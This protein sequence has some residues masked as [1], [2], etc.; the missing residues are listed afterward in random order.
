MGSL[1]LSCIKKTHLCP[2]ADK[3]GEVLLIVVVQSLHVLGV[4][5]EPVHTGEVF[6]LG[7]LL[8]KTPE[9][10]DNAKGGTGD[11]VREVTTRRADSSNNG[12]AALSLRVAET[13]G[14]SSTLVEGSQ[15]GSKVSWVAGVSR[16]LS[17]TP[18]DLSQ[19]LGPSV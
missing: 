8:V 11:R 12:H 10:L 9:H 16:H 2:E 1:V 7:K 5:T 6:P 4:G 17:E 14:P 13:L 15:P 3:L 19:S 18:G